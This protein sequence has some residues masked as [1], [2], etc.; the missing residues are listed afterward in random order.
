MSNVDWSNQCKLR[1]ANSKES[2]Q[3]HEVIKLLIMMKLLEKHK[4]NRTFLRMYSEFLIDDKRKCDI[5]FEDNREKAAYAY[6]IQ[7][8][9]NKKW[10]DS[11]KD[12]YRDWD[13]FLMRTSDLIVVPIRELSDN[14]IELN[15]QLD[16]YVM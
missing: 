16:A 11:T 1:I 3:K 6:E 13:V 12:F 10:L 8:D 5:Y 14:I 7:K 2:F 15:K 4:K 9:I